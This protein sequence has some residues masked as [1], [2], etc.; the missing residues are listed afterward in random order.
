MDKGWVRCVVDGRKWVA[1]SCIFSIGFIMRIFLDILFQAYRGWH[2]AN[3]Y[4]IWFYTSLMNGATYTAKG[5][6]DPT[7]WVLRPI[8]L[9]FPGDMAFY[10]TMVASAML[11]ALTGAAIFLTVNELYERKTAFAAGLIYVG[12]V[13]PLGLSMSGFTHDLIQLLAI[14]ASMWFAVKATKSGLLGGLFWSCAYVAVVESGKLVNNTINM[15]IILTGTYVCYALLQYTLGILFG[16]KRAQSIYPLYIMVVVLMLF[17]TGKTILEPL[18]EGTLNALPQGR[19]GSADVTPVNIYT[20]WTRYNILLAILPFGFVAAVGRRDIFG[21]QATIIGFMLAGIM[22]RGTRIGDIGVAILVAYALAD[23]GVKTKNP[24]QSL[25]NKNP[26]HAIRIVAY[27]A[28]TLLAILFSFDNGFKSL[29][30]TLANTG[31]AHVV[32]VLFASAA[33]AATT[34]FKAGGTARIPR[35]PSPDRNAIGALKEKSEYAIIALIFILAAAYLMWDAIGGYYN[36]S[37]RLLSMTMRV[38]P[39]GA[40]LSLFF[41]LPPTIAAYTCILVVEKSGKAPAQVLACLFIL[42]TAALQAIATSFLGVEGVEYGA[43]IIAYAFVAAAVFSSQTPRVRSDA[44]AASVI[45]SFVALGASGG[46]IMPEYMAVS[47]VAG[48]F[49]WCLL[50][51]KRGTQTLKKAGIMAFTALVLY[52]VLRGYVLYEPA[53]PH[54]EGLL[55]SIFN[56]ARIGEYLEAFFYCALFALVL[57]GFSLL[58]RAELSKETLF[59]AAAVIVILGLTYSVISVYTVEGRKIASDV[60][61]DLYKW[62]SMNNKGGRIL[63][64]WDHGYMAEAVSGLEA[65]STP[66][67]IQYEIHDFLWMPQEQAALNLRR[68]NVSYVMLNSENF[69]VVRDGKTWMYKLMGGLVKDP[70]KDLPIELTEHYTIYKLRHNITDRGFKLIKTEDDQIT[71]TKYLLYEVLDDTPDY[72]GR[73]VGAVAYNV[74]DAKTVRLLGS[75]TQVENS[76]CNR[77]YYTVAN[78]TFGKDEKKELLFP[79][80][81]ASDCTL[82]LAPM[83]P[84]GWTFGGTLAYVN[85]LGERDAEVR[86]YLTYAKSDDVLSTYQIKTHFEAGEKKTIKYGFKGVSEYGDYAVD[87]SA[88]P[89]LRLVTA[90]TPNPQLENAVV[91]TLFC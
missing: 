84:E 86:V 37:I 19:M 21:I 87:L 38:I 3:H 54:M 76:I 25:G 61:Y 16:E 18:I 49:M 90:E 50:G 66:N 65:V 55:E 23:W 31:D 36:L 28:F 1:A 57:W 22:D 5:L 2:S 74:G 89:G 58:M 48:S 8:G 51:G 83:G 73:Y 67:R 7:I 52:Y 9:F 60:E 46:A 10:G 41:L 82:R 6:M 68:Y 27:S 70:K 91:G 20:L 69:N 85:D 56:P 14:T 24:F 53:A 4:E 33:L 11:S 30:T 45:G 59:H 64:A 47:A 71:K 44:F 43:Y 78:V 77:T 32:L 42:M 15:G 79:R 75:T 88:A 12:M 13:E 40:A 29:Q 39:Q 17:A 80:R 62:L 35:L 63:V 26:A 72:G 34:Y 81:N